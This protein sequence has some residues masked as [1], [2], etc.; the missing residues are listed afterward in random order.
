MEGAVA[1]KL[2]FSTGSLYVLDVAQCFALAAIAGCDGVEVMCDDRWSTRDPY[3]LQQLNNHYGMPILV[4][5]TPFSQNVP[6]WKHPGRELE[7]I[8]QTLA[9]AEQVKAETIVVHLP[10]KIGWAQLSLPPWSFRIPWPSQDGVVRHWMTS[11]LA[12]LQ[13]RIPIKIAIENMPGRQIGKR[14]L[15]R[16]WWNTVAEWST[17]HTWLTL[18]TTHWATFGIDPLAAYQ[19]TMSHVAHIHLSNYDGREHRLP[20]YGQLDLA[21]FL[22]QLM[23][24]NYTGTICL[25]L[26]PDALEFQDTDACQ[27]LLC[28]SVAWC[29]KQLRG[30]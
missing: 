23:H 20:Q 15:N 2:I 30:T 19:A 9:L 12:A 16:H 29:R 21:A 4:V 18:D 10:S 8:H 3:Y 26:H 25:E 17:V 5:H 14:T 28:E 6:G 27:R 24:T 7:R 1:P 22:R 11:E 13:Q